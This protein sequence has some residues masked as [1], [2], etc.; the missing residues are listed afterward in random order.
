VS[1]TW[2]FANGPALRLG[3]MLLMAAGLWVGVQQWLGL[4]E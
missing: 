4:V 1:T 2:A 3:S